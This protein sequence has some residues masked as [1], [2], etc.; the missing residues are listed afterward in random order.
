MSHVRILVYWPFA[1]VRSI[2]YFTLSAMTLPVYMLNLAT[3]L[4]LIGL[5]SYYSLLIGLLITVVSLAM[6]AIHIV[7]YESSKLVYVPAMTSITLFDIT[8]KIPGMLAQTRRTIVSINVGGAL[9]PIAVSMSLIY[10]LYVNYPALIMPLLISLLLTSLMVNRVSRIIPTVGV[11]TPAIMPPILAA[12]VSYITVA[13][14]ANAYMY[15]TPVVAY[16]TGVLGTLVGADLLNIRKIMAIA[17][18]IADIGGAGTFDG[19]FF[20]GVLAIFYAS[21]ISML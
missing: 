21:L 4:S 8:F 13:F 17:P 6:S 12:L 14:M 20:T 15:L 1:R 7:I 5:S 2:I 10:E 9:I 18:A 19:I 3:A 16:V 11:V